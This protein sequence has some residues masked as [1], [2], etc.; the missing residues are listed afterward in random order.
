MPER[1]ARDASGRRAE[2][3]A[4]P[5]L[6]AELAR[7]R[8]RD[9]PRLSPSDRQR[10]LRA[11]EV[12]E[13]TGR[14][15]ASLPGRPR[16]PG[17]LAG[18]PAR[19]VLAPDRAALRAAHRGALSTPWSAAAR[20]TR[21]GRSERAGSIRRCRSCA[22]TACRGSIGHLEGEL[23]LDEA[24]ARGQ[25]D[26]RRYAK[27]QFTWFRHQMPGWTWAAPEEAEAVIRAALAGQ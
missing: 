18:V 12:F 4:T 10:I 17:P 27:R 21:C 7:A 25:A 22:R 8:S 6:H 20:S 2:G 24:V 16:R 15:L 1:R 14:P 9:R 23:T 5:E 26:T 19:I 13:A 11:L 3:R